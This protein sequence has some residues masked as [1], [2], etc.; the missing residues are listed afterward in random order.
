MAPLTPE[1]TAD[2]RRRGNTLIP[3][4][5]GDFPFTIS[6]RCGRLMIVTVKGKPVVK[7]HLTSPIS[8]VLAV[9]DT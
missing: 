1:P 3:A 2:K 4:S 5:T 9:T 6:N 7:A 8:D